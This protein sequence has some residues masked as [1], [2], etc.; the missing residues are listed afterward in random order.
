VALT[1]QTEARNSAI[2]DKPRDVFTGQSRSPNM[3]P[4]HMLGMVSYYDPI[5]T[6]SVRRT[7][8]FRYLLL[9]I[10]LFFRYC[11]WKL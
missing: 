1:T 7:V 10:Y 2:A 3:V 6:L 9:D 8:F 4:F 11:R 5:V